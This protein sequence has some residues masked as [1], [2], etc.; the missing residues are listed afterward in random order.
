MQKNQL[1]I[2]DRVRLTLDQTLSFDVAIVGDGAL[3]YDGD[4]CKLIWIALDIIH[5]TAPC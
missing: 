2:S 3:L 4:E 5:W 1:R